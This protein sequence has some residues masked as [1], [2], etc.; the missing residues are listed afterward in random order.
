ML[1]EAMLG[2]GIDKFSLQIQK[3]LHLYIHAYFVINISMDVKF[4]HRYIRGQHPPAENGSQ[5]SMSQALSS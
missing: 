3:V 1:S 2:V 5:Y 4:V